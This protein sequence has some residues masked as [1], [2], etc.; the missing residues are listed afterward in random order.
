LDIQSDDP[1]KQKQKDLHVID[2]YRRSDKTSYECNIFLQLLEY[3]VVTIIMPAL[4]IYPLR[5]Y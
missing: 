2:M 1:N 4:F 5:V 3:S